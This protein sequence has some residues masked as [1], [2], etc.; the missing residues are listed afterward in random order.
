MDIHRHSMYTY[1]NPPHTTTRL[2][3]YTNLRLLHYL[4]DDGSISHRDDHT[5]THTYTH[6]HTHTY[7]HIHTYT[8]LHLLHYLRDHCS[9]SHRDD[10]A[11]QFGRVCPHVLAQMGVLRGHGGVRKKHSVCVNEVCSEKAA[12]RC[13]SLV[14]RVRKCRISRRNCP[15]PS[16]EGL[17]SRF[18]QILS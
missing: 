5:H 13:V 10:L 17:A 9:I 16:E 6:T 3:T 15:C 4:G 8:H 18:D 2:H 11:V 14:G 1:N 12:N 7:T